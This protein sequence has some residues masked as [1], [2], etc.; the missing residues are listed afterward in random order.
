MLVT[1]EKLR[2]GTVRDADQIAPFI[3]GVARMAAKDLQRLEWRREKLRDAFLPASTFL[4]PVETSLSTSIAWR[5]ASPS[6]PIAS[7]RSCF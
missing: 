7:A 5:P 1:I 6:S 3:L 4:A 2:A